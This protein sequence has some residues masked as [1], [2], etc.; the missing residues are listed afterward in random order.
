MSEGVKECLQEAP[1]DNTDVL[2]GDIII[3]QVKQTVGKDP[4]NLE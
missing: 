2:S 1:S 3:E 4:L